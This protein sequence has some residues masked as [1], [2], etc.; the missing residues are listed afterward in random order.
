MGKCPIYLLILL[1][2]KKNK[3]L[4]LITSSWHMK[5]AKFCFNKNNMNV[6][7]F[8]TDYTKKHIKINFEYLLIPNSNIFCKMGDFNKRIYRKYRL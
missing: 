1:E 5:R 6:D 7:L 8:P 2:N 4:L 3:K